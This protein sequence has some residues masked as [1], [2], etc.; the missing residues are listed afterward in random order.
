LASLAVGLVL[1]GGDGL[2]GKARA[3]DPDQIAAAL[4]SRIWWED[5]GSFG[6]QAWGYIYIFGPPATSGQPGWYTGTRVT[7][8]GSYGTREYGFAWM[9]TDNGVVIDHAFARETL[10]FTGF[11]AEYEVLFFQAEGGGLTR[12]AAW[13]SNRSPY[14]PQAVRNLFPW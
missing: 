10:T 1:M 8:Q 7:Y 13:S 6:N 4:R 12:T 11:N 14:T 2:T 9:P 3:A 5:L